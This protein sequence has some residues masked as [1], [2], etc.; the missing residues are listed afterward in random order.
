MAR[1]KAYAANSH[2]PVLF[3]DISYD[4]WCKLSATKQIPA[5]ASWVACLGIVYGP[6][7]KQVSQ[8]A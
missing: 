5:G 3:T 1:Q 7:P 2:R 8:A 6:E 4:Q